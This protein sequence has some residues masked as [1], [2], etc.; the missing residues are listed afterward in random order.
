MRSRRKTRRK[1]ADARAQVD[2]YLD[3][4]A[5]ELSTLEPGDNDVARQALA[6]AS[7]RY[8]S[9]GAQLQNA[10]LD[11]ATGGRAPDRSCKACTRR[12]RPAEPSG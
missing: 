10:E 1:L 6:D 9:A 7:E 4:L 2:P 5:N 3:R 12:A 11:R 8:T